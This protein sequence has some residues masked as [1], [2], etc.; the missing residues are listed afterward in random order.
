MAA[1]NLTL[2]SG[3]IIADSSA[4]LSC[5]QKE[6]KRGGGQNQKGAL[7]RSIEQTF[8]LSFR[9]SLA[10]ATMMGR[11]ERRRKGFASASTS[12]ST[13]SL[14][15]VVRIG[16]AGFHVLD[17]LVILNLLLLVHRELL[18]EPLHHP[19]LHLHLSLQVHRHFFSLPLCVQSRKKKKSLIRQN[20]TP[21]RAVRKRSERT[22]DEQPPPSVLGLLPRLQLPLR[23]CR[24][25]VESKTKLLF[26]S[27]ESK[28]HEVKTRA[29]RREKPHDPDPSDTRPPPSAL[30]P[31]PRRRRPPPRQFQLVPLLL[32]S[33]CLS[34][35]S[36]QNH[37][38]PRV[39]W[40]LRR[41]LRGGTRTIA[42]GGERSIG[43]EGNAVQSASLDAS[44]GVDQHWWKALSAR[45]EINP[46]ILGVGRGGGG[47]T[48]EG[49]R[50]KEAGHLLCNIKTQD[51]TRA[52]SF[53]VETGA[54]PR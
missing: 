14:P 46:Y 7:H 20:Q 10:S 22:M 28:Q 37:R 24:H 34:G 8:P 11:L 19:S 29:G 43:G 53:G 13:Y 44:I 21:N 27:S 18:P 49:E 45:R 6:G 23:A 39:V 51:R 4:T 48:S 38:I 31:L 15:D 52:S 16:P 50:P 25:S 35:V 42:R 3:I 1:S 2:Q 40:Y 5:T 33:L 26:Q 30:L 12:T 54:L 41:S 32:L 36:F 9:P 17:P 47:V